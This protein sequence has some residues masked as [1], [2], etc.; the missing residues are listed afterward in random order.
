MNNTNTQSKW[1]N[2]LQKSIGTAVIASALCA[3]GTGPDLAGH[4]G[5]LTE[6]QRVTQLNEAMPMPDFEF[7]TEPQ[8]E[9]LLDTPERAAPMEMES[10]D[11]KRIFFF[12]DIQVQSA[13]ELKDFHRYTHVVG[14]IEI[15]TQEDT[16]LAWPNLRAVAG[17]LVVSENESV[18]QIEFTNLDRVYGSLL[19]N[20]NPNLEDFSMPDL[21]RVTDRIYI[22]KNY[23]LS[24]CLVQKLEED[25]SKTGQEITLVSFHNQEGEDCSDILD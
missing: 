1:M 4:P 14:N 9:D 13:A 11:E 21:N 10:Q 17:D 20:A 24:D 8:Q 25:L 2:R 15:S 19:I 3:C 23:S 18:T 5:I 12:G 22:T 7:I 16:F 6:E